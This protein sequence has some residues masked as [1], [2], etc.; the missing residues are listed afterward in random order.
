MV[1]AG[2]PLLDDDWAL[3]G[4]VLMMGRMDLGLA[5]FGMK[6]CCSWGGRVL[7]LWASWA[8]SKWRWR[9]M[10]S[11]SLRCDCMLR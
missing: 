6:R 1:L 10:V 11:A 9:V 3:G 5:V 8:D 4:L 7:Y 2:V